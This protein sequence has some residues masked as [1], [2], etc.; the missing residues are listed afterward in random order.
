MKTS[1][2]Y[3]RVCKDWWERSDSS[4]NLSKFKEP[5]YG[6]RQWCILSPVLFFIQRYRLLALE[7]MLDMR[8][9]HESFTLC[10][11][12]VLIADNEIDL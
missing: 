9:H 8:T 4:S 3:W 2:Q 5:T 12:T 7:N 10:N 1:Y 6:E 11:A